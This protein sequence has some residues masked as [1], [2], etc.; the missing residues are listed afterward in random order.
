MQWGYRVKSKRP[1]MMRYNVS[2]ISNIKLHDNQVPNR[3]RREHKMGIPTVMM[4]KETKTFCPEVFAGKSELQV[5]KTDFFLQDLKFFPLQLFIH[6]SSKKKTGIQ[7]RKR[8]TS[9]G[10]VREF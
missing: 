6:T 3:T 4:N 5:V 10:A 1:P 9:L 8:S 7:I 2:G